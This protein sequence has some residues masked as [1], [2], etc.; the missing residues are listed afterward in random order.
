[1]IDIEMFQ[2]KLIQRIQQEY[3]ITISELTDKIKED[4]L[5]CVV[6][7]KI[8]INE[9]KVKE[10]V[11]L[12]QKFF[13]ITVT[14]ELVRWLKAEL[15]IAYFIRCEY[16]TCKFNSERANKGE[17]QLGNCQYIG[18]IELKT[19]LSINLCENCEDCELITCS[20]YQPDEVHHS[21]VVVPW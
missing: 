8:S 17:G 1:M 10:L 6:S 15:R 14:E 19:P 5:S 4:L 20:V 9:P 12:I 16:I 7:K 18:T 2:I 13:N 3:G 21:D 11:E